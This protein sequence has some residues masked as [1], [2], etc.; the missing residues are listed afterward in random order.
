MDNIANRLIDQSSYMMASQS[1]RFLYPDL[2]TPLMDAP[3]FLN[4][5]DTTINV[6]T[7]TLSPTSTQNSNF[8]PPAFTGIFLM[9]FSMLVSTMIAGLISMFVPSLTRGSRQITTYLRYLGEKIGLFTGV[10]E[11]LL[12]SVVSMTQFGREHVQISPN[13][14]AVLHV[15]QKR[16]NRYKDLFKVKETNKTDYYY[17]HNTGDEGHN[18]CTFLDINQL[19]PIEIYRDG[20]KYMKIQCDNNYEQGEDNA[21]NTNTNKLTT[22]KTYSLSILCN[23][24]LEP[25]QTFIENCAKEWEE[26]KKKDKRRYMFTYLGLNEQKNPI[27][28]KDEFI[29]YANFNGLV[30]KKVTEIRDDFAFFESSEGEEW[31]KKRNLPYQ[32][33]HCYYGE[34]GTGKSIVACALANEHNLHIVRIR[35]SDIKTNQEFVKV[36]RNKDFSGTTLEYKDMLYLFDEFDTELEKLDKG[37]NSPDLFQDDNYTKYKAGNEKETDHR[38]SSEPDSEDNN[39]SDYSETDTSTCH[40]KNQPKEQ[41]QEHRQKRKLNSIINSIKHKD[42]DEPVNKKKLLKQLH[43]IKI[44]INMNTSSVTLGVILEEMNGINQMYGRKMIIITNHINKLKTIHKGAFVRPGRIDLMIELTRSTQSEVMDIL[45]LYYPE[46]RISTRS[47]QTIK[48]YQYTPAFITNICKISKTPD[49]FFK[50]LANFSHF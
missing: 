45:S 11:V 5:T 22:R 20:K 12:E 49:T 28:E 46:R 33:T 35:L 31:Y 15:L 3:P 41:K 27:Y 50:N 10:Y 4:I 42:N 13:K 9:S 43:E 44:N 47:M 34:P 29:P 8:F 32:K 19:K 21:R 7:T 37:Q 17:D 24:G 36:L 48:D 39:E 18:N 26:D 30:G 25:I 16:K 2:S 14:I 40:N 23:Y 1:G 6:T 38:V